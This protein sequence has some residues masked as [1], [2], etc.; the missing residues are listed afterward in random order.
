MNEFWVVRDQQLSTIAGWKPQEEIKHSW[1]IKTRHLIYCLALGCSD[2]SQS[3]LADTPDSPHCRVFCMPHCSFS[4]FFAFPTFAYYSL[5]FVWSQ[6]LL[7]PYL[8]LVFQLC[9]QGTAGFSRL[10]SPEGPQFSPTIT[11]ATRPFHI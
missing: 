3:Y 2:L 11:C 8:R 5:N 7:H 9:L 6:D 10:C 4:Y 1:M